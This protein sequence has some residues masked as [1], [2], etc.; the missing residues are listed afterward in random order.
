[1]EGSRVVDSLR[2]L[3]R[4]GARIATCGTCLDHYDLR[5]KLLIGQV[6]TMGQTIQVMAQADRIIRP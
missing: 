2:L 6:G 3:E 5:E 1:M 4:K